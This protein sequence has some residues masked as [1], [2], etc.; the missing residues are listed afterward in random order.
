MPKQEPLEEYGVVRDRRAAEA[1]KDREAADRLWHQL[2]ASG[3]PG[4][5]LRGALRD[6]LREW[7]G[8][9]LEDPALQGWAFC[10]RLCD[11]S[12][13]LAE[14]DP[15]AA[16]EMA[17]LA[18]TLAPKVSGEEPLVCGLQEYAWTHLGNACRARGDLPG[19][20][21]AFR[22]A[23][24]FFAGA[25]GGIWPSVLHRQRLAPL[26][27]R[28]LC[29]QGKLGEAMEK[30]DFALQL[31]MTAP[32][33]GE[34]K[35]VLLLERARLRRRF[36]QTE[37]A[38]QDLVRAD[39][40]AGQGSNSRLA[41]RIAIELGAALCDSGRHA[42]VKKVSAALRK[43][44]EGLEPERSRLLCLDGR[45]AAG[46]GRAKEAEAVLARAPSEFHRRA[47]A[48]RALLFIEVA[49][50]HAREGRT[51]ELKS[52]AESMPRLTEDSG[53]NREAAAILKLF[54]RLAA[55]DKLTPDRALQ[56]AGD[57]TRLSSGR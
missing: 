33:G 44:A 48:D 53:L 8:R 47:I 51:A 22:R 14:S 40:L 38:L 1:K 45:I 9:I 7:K 35:A 52:L 2:Q 43:V 18:V 4:D 21:E 26:T 30:I 11:E 37:T 42:E 55:Q 56:F 41:L 32:D 3:A 54:C 57:F 12:A 17:A 28:L 29:E 20:E 13:E 49:A 16:E 36:G 5:G 27:S 24:T 6:A 39:E 50:L 34:G 46:L 10:E 19:A 25:M 15:D 23:H 31:A